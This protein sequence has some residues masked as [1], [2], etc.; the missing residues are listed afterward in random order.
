MYGCHKIP[1][2]TWSQ[3]LRATAVERNTHSQ[4]V[5]GLSPAVLNVPVSIL[6]QTHTTDVMV[7]SRPL[8][9][10]SHATVS[11]CHHAIAT[12]TSWLKP[13]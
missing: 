8:C 10:P 9:S 4:K 7:E 2:H 11:R 13:C 1:W 5:L 6:A 12:F 3:P